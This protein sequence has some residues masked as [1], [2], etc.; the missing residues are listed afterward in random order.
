MFRGTLVHQPAGEVISVMQ[1]KRF[2]YN[3]KALSLQYEGIDKTAT[4]PIFVTFCDCG[5]IHEVT[6]AVMVN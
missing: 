5:D 6:C 4:I 3:S 2:Y 1:T